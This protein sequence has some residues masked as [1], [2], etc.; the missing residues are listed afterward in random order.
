MWSN[1]NASTEGK[2]TLGMYKVRSSPSQLIEL[3]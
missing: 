1:L 3:Y 2:E